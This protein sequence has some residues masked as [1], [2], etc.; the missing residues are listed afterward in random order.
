MA[1]PSI[2]PVL[3]QHAPRLTRRF[4]ACQRCPNAPIASVGRRDLTTHSIIHRA[5]SQTPFLKAFRTQ[6]TAA[7]A[8]EPAATLSKLG[9]SVGKSTKRKGN[10]PLL[11]GYPRVSSRAAGW[12]LIGSAASV[13]AIVVLGGLTRLT[14]SG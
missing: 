1:Q 3:R 5:K 9:Q 12:W 6:S 2:L 13:Y 10:K 8:Q 11:K 7:I 4:F 14:E